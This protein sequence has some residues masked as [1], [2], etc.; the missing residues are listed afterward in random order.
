MHVAM[1]VV[2]ATLVLVLDEVWLLT[3]IFVSLYF[4]VSSTS[5]GFKSIWSLSVR[6][7]IGLLICPSVRP[8]RF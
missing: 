6:P 1:P 7:F 8:S 2:M 4:P 3:L 5:P